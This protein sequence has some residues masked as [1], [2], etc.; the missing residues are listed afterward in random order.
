MQTLFDPMNC[1]QIM[2]NKNEGDC[3][4]KISLWQGTHKLCSKKQTPPSEAG[5]VGSESKFLLADSSP[6]ELCLVM[7]IKRFTA[8]PRKDLSVCELRFS[9]GVGGRAE[10]HWRNVFHQPDTSISLWHEGK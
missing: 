4:I 7:K 9:G 10:E 2:S 5:T 8:F 3:Y 1:F 6:N